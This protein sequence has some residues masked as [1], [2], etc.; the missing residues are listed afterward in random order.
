MCVTVSTDVLRGLR[1]H[2]LLELELQAVMNY[3][4]WV[5]G[6]ELRTSARAVHWFLSPELPL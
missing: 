3:L 4:I 5:L 6:I 1:R 2:I